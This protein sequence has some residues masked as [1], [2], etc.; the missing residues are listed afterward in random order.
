M[1]LNSLQLLK[2]ITFN[3]FL[4]SLSKSVLQRDNSKYERKLFLTIGNALWINFM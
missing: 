4:F 2:T 3:G 1:L